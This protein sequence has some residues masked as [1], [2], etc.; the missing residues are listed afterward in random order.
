MTRASKIV[1]KDE[2]IYPEEPITDKQKL[3]PRVGGELPIPL[4][5]VGTTQGLFYEHKFNTTCKTRAPYCLKPYDWTFEGD[6]YLSMYLIYMNCDSEYEAAMTLLG[7]WPHWRKL[8]RAKWF[9]IHL[10][11]W[12]EELEIRENALAKSKLIQLTEAGNVTAA[13]TLLTGKKSAVGKPKKSG[14]R[15]ADDKDSDDLDAMLGRAES[16]PSPKQQH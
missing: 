6:T 9:K 10:D 7:S 16:T 5:L 13:R 2:D 11:A 15:K 8:A 14:K 12:N 3:L 4:E 1:I